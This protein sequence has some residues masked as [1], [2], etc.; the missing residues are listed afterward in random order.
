MAEVRW[1]VR[2]SAR[3]PD[4]SA[5]D[6][7]AA[8]AGRGF[9]AGPKSFLGA[10]F[11]VAGCRSARE[12]PGGPEVPRVAWSGV[13]AR[14]GVGD[15]QVVALFRGVCVGGLGALLRTVTAVC[16]YRPACRSPEGLWG[17][18]VTSLTCPVRINVSR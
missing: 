5:R 6:L 17:G 14:T 8:G 9:T 15:G 16:P 1:W 12:V 18:A 3:V 4:R 11:R 13:F 10:S 7:L 2:R